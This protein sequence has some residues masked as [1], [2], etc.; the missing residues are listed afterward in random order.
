LLTLAIQHTVRKSESNQG[1]LG[2]CWGSLVE[3]GH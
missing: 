2:F 3:G 1:Q